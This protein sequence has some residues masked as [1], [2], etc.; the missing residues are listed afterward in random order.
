[1]PFQDSVMTNEKFV[2]FNMVGIV[3]N[4]EM[5]QVEYG[6]CTRPFLR[7]PVMQ[8]IQCC[9]VEGVA[10]ETTID[11]ISSEKGLEARVSICVVLENCSSVKSMVWWCQCT[12]ETFE[13]VKLTN[14]MDLLLLILY[15]TNY[16]FP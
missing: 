6:I 14:K 16:A 10:C 5:A 4:L 7:V 9:E 8:Y 12:F 3:R 13:T 2:R 1:M 11:T 15:M